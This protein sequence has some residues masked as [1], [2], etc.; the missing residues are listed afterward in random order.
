[1]DLFRFFYGVEVFRE[2]SGGKKTDFSWDKMAG[3]YV[4][5]FVVSLI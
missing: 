1:L 2:G 4:Y 3:A 5:T